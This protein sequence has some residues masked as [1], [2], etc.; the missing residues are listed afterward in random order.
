M[1][2][3]KLSPEE[4]SEVVAKIRS[5]YQF[6]CRTFFKSSRLKDEFENRYVMTLKKGYDISNFLLAEISVIEE[7]IRKEEDRIAQSKPNTEKKHN[8]FA[9]RIV[10]GNLER[11]K[12][13]PKIRIHNDANEEIKHLSG[14]LNEMYETQLPV[15]HGIIRHIEGNLNLKALENQE[16]RLRV[17]AYGGKTL[18]PAQLSRYFAYLNRFPRDYRAIEWEEKEYILESAFLLH[19][20]FDTLSIILETTPTIPQ[21]EQ[22]QLM[23]IIAYI[24]GLIEDFRLKEFKR[25]R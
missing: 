19:D 2:Y 14:A 9:D 24:K 15:L 13:Y 23:D 25:K 17:L 4:I 16:S 8:N 6:Y 5:K 1:G 7:L 18:I 22:K 3:R 12:K 10:Q 20:M 11:I 21:K